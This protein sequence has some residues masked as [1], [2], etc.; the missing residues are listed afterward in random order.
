MI[1]WLTPCSWQLVVAWVFYFAVHSL[2]ASITV[3][4]LV[5]RYRS[6]LMP[7]Y[8]LA[9][10][11]VATLLLALPFYLLFKCDSPAFITW[12]DS[13]RWI[14][15]LMMSMAVLLFLW[16]T[17]YYDGSAFLGLRQAR[18]GIRTVEDQEQFQL[19][20]VHRFVRHP[21]Y[22]VALLLIWS[23]NMNQSLF[24]SAVL[25]T[26]YFFIGSR[27]EETKLVAY[28]GDVYR[29]YRARVPGIIPLPWKYLTREQADRLISSGNRA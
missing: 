12:P 1:D 4:Q 7:Y 25:L 15:W 18:E 22:L 13:L 28:H 10:N 8:R 3:K 20:P 21:W 16:T 11:A 29:E 24:I 9:F 19:S 5:A 17:R 6:G 2:F 26:G 23:Q 27:W 14:S